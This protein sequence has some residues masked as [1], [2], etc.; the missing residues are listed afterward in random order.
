ML[1]ITKNVL[2]VIINVL[3]YIFNNFQLKKLTEIEIPFSWP[4]ELF[5][6]NEDFIF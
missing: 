4:S 6:K 3:S 2:I 5:V 1:N